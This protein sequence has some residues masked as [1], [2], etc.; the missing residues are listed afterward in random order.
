M[1]PFDVNEA[2]ESGRLRALLARVGTPIGPYDVMIAGT[3]LAHGLTLV[4][5]N[6]TEFSRVPGLQLQNWRLPANEVREIPAEYRVSVRCSHRQT[7]SGAQKA[8]TRSA[9]PA[10]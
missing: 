6:T 2:H 3:A 10:R 1:I 7:Y 4:S 8:V 5:A 9:V